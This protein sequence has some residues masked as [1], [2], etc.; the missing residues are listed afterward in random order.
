MLD[1]PQVLNI[2]IFFWENHWE[3]HP[4]MGIRDTWFLPLITCVQFFKK[5]PK[6]PFQ[7]FFEHISVIAGFPTLDKDPEPTSKPEPSQENL[8][9]TLDWPSRYLNEAN[10]S[11]NCVTVN[12]TV[13]LGQSLSKP[14]AELSMPER[15]VQPDVRPRA[16]IWKINVLPAHTRWCPIVN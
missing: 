12:E 2:N 6:R 15:G 13:R 16:A 3:K 7:P 9:P 4:Y 8:K 1:S 14:P 5:V 11:K 10:T